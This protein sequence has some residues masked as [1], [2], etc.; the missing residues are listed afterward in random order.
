MADY[1]GYKDM[2]IENLTDP[3]RNDNLWEER[4]RDDNSFVIQVKAKNQRDHEQNSSDI[5]IFVIFVLKNH[6]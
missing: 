2:E 1:S 6:I 4:F 3:L 5:I